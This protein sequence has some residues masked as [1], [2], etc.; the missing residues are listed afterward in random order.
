MDGAVNLDVHT[1]GVIG[2]A[3]GFTIALSF[4][5]LGMVLRGMPALSIWSA[6]FF[7]LTVAGWAGGYDEGSD[8]LSRIVGS[9]LIAIA[10]GSMLI[11]IAVHIGYP[12]RWRW[13]A[14]VIAVFLVIQVAF[15]LSPP[16]PG[17]EGAVFGLKSVV[18]DMWMVS[19][20]LFRAP[21]ELRT[22]CVFTALVFLVD[23]FFYLARGAVSLHP[24]MNAH[25]LLPVLLTT[26]NYLF[27]ILC[28]FL[29]STGFTLMLAQ[30]L[31]HDLRVSAATDGLTGL[32]NRTAV[33]LEANRRLGAARGQSHAVLLFDLDNFKA[34]NDEWGHAAGD[35]VLKHFADTLRAANL[36]AHAL[37]SRYGGEEFLILLPGAS[38]AVAA[39]LAES[40]R[41]RIEHAPAFY[42]GEPIGFTTSVGVSA[43]LALEVR[44]LVEAADEALYRA[45]H[46]GRNRVEVAESPRDVR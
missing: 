34:V 6:A 11:G 8:F 29:L 10:N 31:V 44:G 45:K 22:G 21:P 27:G 35:A 1:L 9:V 23:T 4:A 2:L 14:L 40:L 3:V 36:P 41:A 38:P 5:L 16:A 32:L 33:V 24:E 17:F 7:L 42:A 43:G 46:A 25:D 20:L 39:C 18:W 37:F 28:T 26:S 19:L 12:L 13:P 15:L 30:R